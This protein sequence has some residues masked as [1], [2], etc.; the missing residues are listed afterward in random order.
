MDEFETLYREQYAH[1][2]HFLHNLCTDDDIAEELTNETF[3]QAFLS[4]RKFRGDSKVFTWLASIAKHT[5]YKYLRR[6]KKQTISLDQMPDGF[7]AAAADLPEAYTLNGEIQAAVKQNIAKMPQKYR[8]VIV[9]RTYTQMPFSEIAKTLRI[10][11]NSAK[12]LYFRAKKMLS[13]DL[14]NEFDL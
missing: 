13:E 9:L 5:Y 4:F 14:K 8:D 1:I 7:V 2:R 12:V 10:S 6:N 11:E 3:Y